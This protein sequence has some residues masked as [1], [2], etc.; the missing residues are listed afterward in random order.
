MLC[1]Q[2]I[3]INVFILLNIVRII[4]IVI[5]LYNKWTFRK[6]KPKN[7]DSSLTFLPSW[8]RFSP[9]IRWVRHIPC[10]FV[11]SHRNIHWPWGVNWYKDIPGHGISLN[12]EFSLEQNMYMKNLEDSELIL[13]RKNQIRR[14]FLP[15]HLNSSE[16]KVNMSVVERRSNEA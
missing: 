8:I 9:R 3:C 13:L 12:T 10:N 16:A 6:S 5:S 1:A 15:P 2:F 11:P 14:Q 7:I 4:I